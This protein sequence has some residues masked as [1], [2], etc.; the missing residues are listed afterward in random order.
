LSLLAIDV[1]ALPQ[2]FSPNLPRGWI[3]AVLFLV[4]GFLA[5]AWV[6]RVV[7]ELLRPETPA[8]LE[9]TTTR[10]I[11]A[12]DLALI[13]PLAILAGILLLRRW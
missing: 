4:G 12:M 10:V 7:P 9:N 5:L 2:S 3:A 1:A 13:A 11:Q 6:A 8:A